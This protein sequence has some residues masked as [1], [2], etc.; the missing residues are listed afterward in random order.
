MRLK[1]ASGLSAV[2]MAAPSSAGGSS[3][4]SNINYENLGELST[5]A[6]HAVFYKAREPST[7]RIFAVKR[8]KPQVGAGAKRFRQAIELEGEL[9]VEVQGRVSTSITDKYW[10]ILSLSCMMFF[11]LTLGVANIVSS[12][13]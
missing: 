13:I 3:W 10:K 4:L 8:F 7:N 6:A 11:F 12:L 1:V 2:I 9:L 5:V